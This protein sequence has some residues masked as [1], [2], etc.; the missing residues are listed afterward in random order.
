MLFFHVQRLKPAGGNQQKQKQNPAFFHFRNSSLSRS[1]LGDDIDD[2]VRNDD[3]FNDFLTFQ[4]A[5][6]IV[7]IQRRL[8]KVLFEASFGISIV[9]RILPQT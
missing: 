3:N 7:D 9:P 6:D 4:L 5:F 2:F 1:G 8:F